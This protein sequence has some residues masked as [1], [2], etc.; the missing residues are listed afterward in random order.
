MINLIL[1]KEQTDLVNQPISGSLF[2]EGPAGVGKTTVTIARYEH[3][4]NAGIPAETILLLAPQRTLLLPYL[5]T[6]QSTAIPN[7]GSASL[8][9][10]GGLARRLVSLFWPMIAGQVG[11]KKPEAPPVFLT[12]ETSQYYM[13]R[14]VLPLIEKGYFSTITIDRNRLYSQIIDNLNKAAGAGFPHTQIGER[15]KTAWVGEPA[16]HHVYDEAQECA[17]RFRV[18]CLENNLLDFSIQ[19]EVFT[20]LL[21]PSALCRR[22]LMQNYRHLIYENLEEDIPV[23]QNIVKQWLP[24]FDSAWLVYDLDGGYR[25]FLG[26]DPDNGYTLNEVCEHKAALTH[27]WNTPP[28]LIAL[29]DSL[30]NSLST[31][32]NTPNP[33]LNKA[34]K[35]VNRNFYPE[36]IESVCQEIYSLIETGQVKPGEIVILAPYISDS[37][38]F[39]VMSRLETL[40][41]LAQSH[42]PSRSLKDEPATSC[43]I[44]LTKLAHPQWKISC[45]HPEISQALMVAIQDLDLVRADLL[46]RI[47]FR[48]NRWEEGFS[49]FDGIQTDKQERISFWVGERFEKIRHWLEEYRTGTSQELDVFLSRIFGELLSQPGFGFHANLDAAAVA[50]RLIESVQKFR[51]VVSTAL[52]IEVDHIGKEYI[53]MVTNGVVA[54][55]YLQSWDIAASNAVLIAPAYTYL[56]SN[57][58]SRFQF[59]LDTGS[60]GWWERLYQPL[61]HPVVLSQRWLSNKVWTDFEEQNYNNKTTTRLVSGLVTRCSERV[62]LCISRVNQHGDETRGQLLQAVQSIL[63]GLPKPEE[64]FLV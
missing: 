60:Q 49:S 1:S 12:L 45:S 58:S 62:Y 10:L 61:T 23:F 21:W 48:P 63:R 24:D 31:S 4:L 37:L 54:A 42:R 27:L 3:M 59:W 5:Q 11:F 55:Q 34:M 52:I 44:A 9:T 8:A 33:A 32:G 13:A 15:L 30:V 35:I 17:N 43:L 40:G 38:R 16:Q 14:L 53:Q 39:S 41:I 56:M 19:V 50:A 36:M 47:C 18:F 46:S 22:Y 64:M 20:Q 7:G 51:Q 6:T 28:P 26:A 2:L 29:R 25:T 57:R